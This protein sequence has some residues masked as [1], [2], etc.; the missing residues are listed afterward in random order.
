M[1]PPLIRAFQKGFDED[2]HSVHEKFKTENPL[3]NMLG[4]EAQSLLDIL[5][6]LAVLEI[7]YKRLYSYGDEIDW[8]RLFDTSTEFFDLVTITPPG[9]LA[10]HLTR[11]DLAAF[12]SLDPQSVIDNGPRFQV[13][14]RRWDRQCTEAQ[15]IVKFKSGFRSHLICLVNVS[16]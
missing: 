8:T 15:E 14:H 13:L 7:R 1:T 4:Q 11:D 16:L 2:Q 10:Q 9:E 3:R 12:R 6:K 5:K